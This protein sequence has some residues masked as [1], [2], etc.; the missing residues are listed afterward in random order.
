MTKPGTVA[1]PD[2]SHIQTNKVLSSN[3]Q[4]IS[5]LR[6]TANKYVLDYG[7]MMKA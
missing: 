4:A 1:V 5:A 7:D 3:S 2:M 6:Y